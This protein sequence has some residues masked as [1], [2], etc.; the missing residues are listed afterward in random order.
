MYRIRWMNGHPGFSASSYGDAIAD[1]YDELFSPDGNGMYGAR[2]TEDTVD[3]LVTLADGGPALEVGAGTGRVALA[4]SQR[5]ID[6]T[7][8]EVSAEMVRRLRAKPGGASL[9]VVHGDFLTVPLQGR[10]RLIYTVFNTLDAF[11][12]QENQLEFFRRA[13]ERMT[14]DGK[15]VIENVVPPDLRSSGLLLRRVTADHVLASAV[16]YDAASQTSVK[17]HILFRDG[18]MRMF[19]LAAR[20]IWP[21]E[22]DLM[23][24][25]TGLCLHSRYGGW[26]LERYT[27]SSKRHVSTYTFHDA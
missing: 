12:T 14:G 26:H 18:V 3:F 17:Q 27:A 13:G 2:E 19:P 6:V 23:A 4:L 25:L 8:V 9:P 11:T 10:F 21:S 5:G 20:H 22:M 16:S 24:R 1:V 7:A 15:L